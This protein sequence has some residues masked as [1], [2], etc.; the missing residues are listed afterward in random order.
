MD[1]AT[2]YQQGERTLRDVRRQL[3]SLYEHWTVLQCHLPPCTALAVGLSAN[4]ASSTGR[5]GRP[6]VFV[7]V[8]MVEYL[9]CN[10]YTWDEIARSML[11]SRTTIWRKLREAGIT[12]EKYSSISDDD[13]D[14]QVG[15]LQMC[16]PHCGQVLLRSMLQA[17]GV[18]VPRYRLR[19]SMHRVDPEHCSS[20]WHQK[21]RR[22]LCSRTKLTLA[23]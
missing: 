21:I 20:R 4:H 13:L 14:S 8:A 10:G 5:K 2:E 3:V 15:M 23:Y 16:H 22:I 6:P 12:L 17:Q 19:E 7:N 11:V 1:D 9:R 18:H